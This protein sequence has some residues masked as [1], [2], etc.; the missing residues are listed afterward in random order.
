MKRLALAAVVVA[1]SACSKTGNKPMDTTPAMAPMPMDT[2][3]MKDSARRA[4]SIRADSIR[5]D[6]I[7]KADSMAMKKG[8]K[9]GGG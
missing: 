9:K 8:T 2:A 6:S 3:M 1:L 4:D 5:K 7:R